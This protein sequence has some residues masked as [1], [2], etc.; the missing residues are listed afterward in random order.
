MRGFDQVTSWQRLG[1]N[2]RVQERQAREYCESL[3]EVNA[4]AR[5]RVCT[6][7]QMAVYVGY[8]KIRNGQREKIEMMGMRKKST[9]KQEYE[10]S[11]GCV[12]E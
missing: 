2:L 6:K 4:N 3:V 12:K 11:E 1:F 7:I 5:W 8:V 10:K 9:R